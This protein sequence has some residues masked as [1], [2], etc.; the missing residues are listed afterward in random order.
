MTKNYNIGEDKV[1]HQQEEVT[2]RQLSLGVVH[3]ISLSTQ[4]MYIEL[5]HSFC[6]RLRLSQSTFTDF[7]PLPQYSDFNDF[8]IG[9]YRKHIWKRGNT[10][11]QVLFSLFSQCFLPCC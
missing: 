2:H 1:K 5:A 11:K 8:E 6:L 9:D 3:V 4:H 7:N 10:G